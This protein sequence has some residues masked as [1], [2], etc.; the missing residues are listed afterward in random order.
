MEVFE[1][2]EAMPQMHRVVYLPVVD[3][4]S[5]ISVWRKKKQECELDMLF[6][7]RDSDAFTLHAKTEVSNKRMQENWAKNSL[8]ILLFRL[9]L[10]SVLDSLGGL[11]D[12]EGP[13]NLVG[14][15]R[16]IRLSLL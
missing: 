15:Y 11:E 5:C 14:Q 6:W 7:Y 9:F 10:P 4:A 2:I 3:A 12:L 13:L 1:A 8:P 16:R